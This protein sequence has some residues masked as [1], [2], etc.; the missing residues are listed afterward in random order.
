ME[1][2]EYPALPPAG[3]VLIF[4]KPSGM[5]SH[6]AVNLARRL[7]GTKQAGHTGTLDPLAT[8]VLCILVGRAVKASEYT[9][10]HPKT[11][12]AEVRL[13]TVTDTDDIT[14]TVLAETGVGASEE[15]FRAAAGSLLGTT[16]QVPPQ[17]SALK[18]DG[19][20]MYEIARSGGSVEAEARPVTVSS[21]TCRA[22]GPRDFTLWCTVSSGTYV[23][24]LCRDIGKLLGTGA[25][26]AGLRRLSACGFD[27]TQASTREALEESDAAA[28]GALLRPTEDL[29]RGL[30][31][32]TLPP[33]FERLFRSGC[34]IYLRKL[35][36]PAPPDGAFVRIRGVGCGFF[37]L[38]SV[39]TYDDGPAV[40][41]EKLFAL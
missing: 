41:S 34:E 13:G 22:N 35:G 37:A 25:C 26:M 1:T 28:L 36:I 20:R 21:L 11:Y 16:Y 32:V 15:A 30:P 24:S 2:G 18:V 6:A 19:R 10:S 5:S 23:R 8:G 27:I 4:D 39:H 17:Y 3:G 40:K 31:E 14:G 12:R 7:F 38:G 9:L 33:F 29:F